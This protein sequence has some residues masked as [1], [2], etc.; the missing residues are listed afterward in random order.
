MRKAAIL[1]FSIPFLMAISLAP[2]LAAGEVAIYTGTVQWISKAG[3]DT[4]AQIC[5]DMLNAAGIP[6]TWFDSDGDMAALASW[7]RSV[8]GDGGFDVCVLYGDI[9]PDLYPQGNTQP[10]GSVAEMFVETTDGDAFLNHADYMFWGLAGRNQE[11]GIQ[12]IMDI[13]GLVMW[14]DNTPM[15]VTAEGRAIAPSL[16]NFNTDRPFHLD[17]LAGDWVAEAILAQNAAGNRAD[18]VIV[19]DGNRGRLIPVYQT[20]DQLEDPKGAVAAEII[21]WLMEKEGGSTAVEAK[22]KLSTTW[23]ALKTQK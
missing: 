11:G 13:P 19:R 3:A 7:V 22:G 17:Q 5:V 23:A 18:P 6:N 10:N 16:G 20:A 14:D 1:L 9:P 8:T 2:V 21:M 12:N 4:Q 15:V